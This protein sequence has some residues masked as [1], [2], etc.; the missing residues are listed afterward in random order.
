MIEGA[1]H[2]KEI[3]A[4]VV[5]AVYLTG[6][7]ELKELIPNSILELLE[8]FRELAPEELPSKLPPERS[9]QHDIDL[10]PGATLS[11]HPHYR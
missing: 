3:H 5:K 2:T 8:G 10:V 7:T 4:L 1:R 9:I 6:V 11:N